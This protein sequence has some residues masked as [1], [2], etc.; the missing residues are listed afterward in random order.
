[1][2]DERLSTFETALA[3]L[4]GEE[5][6]HSDKPAD[7]GGD[8]WYG[9]S[10][11]SYPTL[12]PWPPT[13]EVAAAVY[14]RDF[15]DAGH[16]DLLPPAVAVALFDSRINQGPGRAVHWL[17]HLLGVPEDGVV[18]P[19][20]AARA[21]VNPGHTLRQFCAYRG[22]KYAEAKNDQGEPLFPIFGMDW[23][24]RLLDCYRVCLAL[25]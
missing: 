4:L 18:G 25:L 6:V 23:M 11:R 9:I 13:R 16:L 1:M 21:A 12:T 10:R 22:V 14:K 17:Q 2:P 15:W 19:T 8:T 5:G 24:T 20:T 7:P 3:F